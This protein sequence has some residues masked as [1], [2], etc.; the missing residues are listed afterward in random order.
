[1]GR[2]AFKLIV[3][4][5]VTFAVLAAPAWTQDGSSSR[6]WG[7][8][9]H[10]ITSIS[11]C[12]PNGAVSSASCPDSTYDTQQIVLGPN[13]SVINSNGI[14]GATDEHA[15]VFPPGSLQGNSDYLFFIASGTTAVNPDI[16]VLVL[17]GG[18][19]P[20]AN[21]QWTMNFSA[22][23]GSYAEGPAPVFI[24]PTVQTRCPKVSSGLASDQDQTFDLNY[25]AAGSLVKDPTNHP[26]SLLMIYEGANTCIGELGP[27]STGEGSY[28]TTGIATSTDYG[29]TW[30]TYAA[31][32][33]F[34]FVDLP[35]ANKTQGPNAPLGATGSLVCMGNDCS[36]SPA[37]SYG[38]YA[39]LSLTVPLSTIM[40]AGNM[41]NDKLGLGEPS[42]F[43]DDIRGGTPYV[44]VITGFNVGDGTGG[45]AFPDARKTD[46]IIS[47]AQLN[48]GTAPLTFYK[49]DGTSFSAAGLGGQPHQLLPD[50]SFAGCGD[51][52]QKRSA[53]SIS[54][55]EET[56][57]YLL[58][59]V[60]NSPGDPK[61]G[62]A[63]QNAAGS[64]WF[65]STSYDLSDP[66]QW[67]TPQEVIGSWNQWQTGA[68][69]SFN[70]WYPTLMSL[71]HAPGRLGTQGYAFYLWG[72]LGGGNGNQP[73]PR[74]YSSRRFSI[75]TR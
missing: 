63:Q 3:G 57:Q 68:C 67:T 74:Q 46:L 47:R 14:H 34:D 31:A 27:L 44:Y 66:T 17:S 39:A 38:R 49:W 28:I 54:Y 55:V 48:R 24:A 42:A 19:G 70:G 75:T 8:R 4:S 5:A 13:G 15:S 64:A 11:V 52:S 62:S 56:Q 10:A 53:G 37:A 58:L 9:P 12:S 32:Q 29:R 71:Q 25:A 41:L 43:V 18:A 1:M 16:G 45:P 69:A 26:G 21:G 72:C 36:Q 20:D 65:Y 51:L 30:P 23:Y 59:F 22:N 35:F 33:T 50:G 61:A 2:S 7:N 73:P 60:C 40:P 6:D